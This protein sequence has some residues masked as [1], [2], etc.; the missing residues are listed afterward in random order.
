MLDT[1]GKLPIAQT[2]QAELSAAPLKGTLPVLKLTIYSTSKIIPCQRICTEK[3]LDISI[4][5]LHHV[6]GKIMAQVPR[7][8]MREGEC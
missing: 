6:C 7:V 3:A 8:M 2:R 4:A 5:G 1:I